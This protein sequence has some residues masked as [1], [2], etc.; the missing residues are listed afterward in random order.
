MCKITPCI[1]K[2]IFADGLCYYHYKYSDSKPAKEKKVYEIPKESKKRAKQ[3]RID[4]KQNKEIISER[5]LCEMKLPGCTIYAEGIQHIRGR[6]GK[7]L[8]DKENK[9]PACNHCNRRAETHPKEAR[10]K[11]VSKSRLSKD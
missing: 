8:T 1:N 5:P 7:R 3:N 6:I 4:R 2:D 9:I 11:K 10:E